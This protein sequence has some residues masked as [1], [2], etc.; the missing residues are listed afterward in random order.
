MPETRFDR[1]V[2]GFFRVLVVLFFVAGLV[3]AFLPA[4]VPYPWER[5]YRVHV[6]VVVPESQQ[7][8]E[9]RLDRWEARQR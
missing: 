1:F 3:G 2:D 9:A 5:E 6:G 7:E 8:A 4:F